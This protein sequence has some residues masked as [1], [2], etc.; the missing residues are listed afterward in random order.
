[1]VW[2]GIWLQ[3]TWVNSLLGKQLG[4]IGIP[5][6]VFALV[7]IAYFSWENLKWSLQERLENTWLEKPLM[8]LGKPFRWLQERW[9][10]SLLGKQMT[11]LHEQVLNSFVRWA[12]LNRPQ[13]NL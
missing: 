4:E 7:V 6:L 10:N 8:W 13:W 5:G 1:M 9:V 12:R 11:W 3:E 2:L